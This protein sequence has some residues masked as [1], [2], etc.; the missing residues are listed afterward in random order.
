ME[1][2]PN[3][4]GEPIG[5]SSSTF[6]CH[7]SNLTLFIIIS[8]SGVFR[9]VGRIVADR[10]CMILFSNTGQPIYRRI[11]VAEDNKTTQDIVGTF[12]EPLKFKVGLACNSTEALVVFIESP[13]VLVLTDLQMP[14]M[15]GWGLTP[16]IK[17]R[18][19]KT[20]V[21]LMTGAERDTVR[22]EVERMP[23]DSVVFKPF[24]LEDLQS[25]V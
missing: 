2:P 25:A 18:S 11:L 20:P 22:K 9:V 14:A 13:F 24:A 10:I 23:V 5:S 7:S 8:I 3:I 16:C 12:F 4:E 1:A 6:L 19:S 17:Q 21:V 15:E